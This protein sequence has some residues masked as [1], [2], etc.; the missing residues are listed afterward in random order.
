[1]KFQGKA[2]K[3][4]KFWLA[5]I[6]FL[7]LM[8]QGRTKKELLLMVEDLFI[9]LADKKGFEVYV[10]CFRDGVLEI[11]SNDNKVMIGLLLKRQRQLN[12]LTVQEMA[13]RLGSSSKN[14]YARYEQ[15]KTLP[16]ID[17]L[18]ELLGAA[19]SVSDVVI[20]EARLA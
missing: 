13:E 16:S 8:T 1:M 19:G 6:P 12:N 7:E 18:Q 10:K 11:G 15:G 4:G 5:E 3:S 2:F 14:A 20:S 17:K 9:T